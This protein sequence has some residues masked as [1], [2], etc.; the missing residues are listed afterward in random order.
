MAEPYLSADSI[1]YNLD[2]PRAF[3]RHERFLI[4]SLM[5][6]FLGLISRVT[7]LPSLN[8]LAWFLMDLVIL[9]ILSKN[10]T[11]FLI[12]FRW[13]LLLLLW[14]FLAISSGLW[15]INP[16]VSFYHGIQ[17]GFN[18]LA[19]MVIATALG[20]S[21]FLSILRLFGFVFYYSC[22]GHLVFSP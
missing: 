3:T 18:T 7:I 13:N 16:S 15:S 11:K 21:R 17:F 1:S 20:L 12:V 10:A 22:R 2:R 5:A 9:S 4:D 19:G 8:T 14:P 6:L